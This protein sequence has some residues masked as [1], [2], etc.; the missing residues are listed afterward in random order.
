[1][2]D[3]DDDH[4]EQ[5]EFV[6]T[7]HAVLF[8]ISGTAADPAH[9][10]AIRGLV[11]RDTRYT[12]MD[13]HGMPSGGDWALQ[14]SGAVT[15]TGTVDVLIDHCRFTRVD[16]NGVFLG[17]YNRNATVQDSDFEWIGDSAMCAW[18][19]TSANLN[20]NGSRTVPGGYKVGPDGRGGEQPRGTNILRNVV[21]EI[22]IWQKQSSMWFQAVTAQTTL[23]GNI[24]FNGPRAALNFNDGFG[25]GDNISGNLFVNAVRESGD[26]GPW[27]SWDRVPYITE[28]RYGNGTGSVLPL[29]RTIHH[30]FILGTYNTQEAIDNDDGSSYY[31]THHNV[32]VYGD[33]GLKVNFGAHDNKHRGNMYAY[34][35]SCFYG[36]P[37]ASCATPSDLANAEFSSN[38]CIFRNTDG[39]ASDCGR[40][41]SGVVV[42][43]NSVFSPDGTLQ[44]CTRKGQG[45]GP[46]RTL[47]SWISDGHDSASSVSKWPSDSA[48]ISQARRL[49][50]F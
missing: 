14:R 34:V 31:D 17:G 7:Q 41:T 30:N 26:H 44:V 38:T 23:E 10:I 15:M 46:P 32:F 47:A 42:G 1:M 35:G 39:Y 25:G 2:D 36:N 6:A 45:E 3:D 43:N 22:G 29:P 37:C 28:L 33:N 4:D 16:G 5:D 9:H 48:V 50:S 21:H 18:G 8:N 27:N 40:F 13:A 12:Y 19:D 49:L 11:L 24:F 20:E